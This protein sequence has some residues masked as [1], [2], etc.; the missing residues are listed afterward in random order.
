M[1]RSI[2]AD[3]HPPTLTDFRP[4]SVQRITA[5]RCLHLFAAFLVGLILC[6]FAIPTGAEGDTSSKL[7]SPIR[8]LLSKIQRL[9][10]TRANVRDRSVS[11]LSDT[12]VRIDSGG[13]LQVYL[14]VTA[15]GKKEL[16]ALETLGFEVEVINLKLSMVQGKVPVDRLYDLAGLVFVSRVTTP[17]YGVPR[18]GSVSTEGVAIHLAD[19]LHA[20]GIDG[21]GVKV[22]VISDGVNSRD[23]AV[24][25]GDLPQDVVVFGSCEESAPDGPSCVRGSTCNEGT[26]ILEIVHDIAPGATLGFGSASTT[27]EFIAR[28]EELTETFGAQRFTLISNVPSALLNQSGGVGRSVP[29]NGKSN[30]CVGTSQYPPKHL[31]PARVIGIGLPFVL[32]SMYWVGTSIGWCSCKAPGSG[33]LVSLVNLRQVGL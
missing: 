33:P 29:S 28:V 6:V 12:S 26:A 9:D 5:S 11:H 22:G 31:S 3:S 23:E 24:A 25:T 10:S 19:Q 1:I 30:T 7:S 14:Y 16:E 21:T 32:W 27:L 15:L 8:T 13:R 17:R 20:R 4:E 18:T 2:A